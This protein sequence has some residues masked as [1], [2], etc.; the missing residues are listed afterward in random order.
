MYMYSIN[1]VF[2][3][4]VF[5]IPGKLFTFSFQLCITLNNIMHV[6]QYLSRL[7]EALRFDEICTNMATKHENADV[8]VRNRQVRV[9]CCCGRSELEHCGSTCP[10]FADVGE[11]GAQCRP[12]DEC[13]RAEDHQIDHRQDGGRRHKLLQTI[14]AKR[15]CTE[16]G[17]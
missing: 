9:T 1:S 15:T 5:C 11:P 12:R 7:P 3:C 8:G 10:S 13:S 4:V 17:Q 6:R 2:T 16:F 14:H